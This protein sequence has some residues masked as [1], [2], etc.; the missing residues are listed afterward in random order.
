MKEMKKSI[1]VFGA[2]LIALLMVS[3]ATAAIILPLSEKNTQRYIVSDTQRYIVSETEVILTISDIPLLEMAMDMLDNPNEQEA[4]QAVI[5]FIED[6]GQITM[7]E[8]DELLGPFNLGIILDGEV[9]GNS[10]MVRLLRYFGFFAGPCNFN[11]IS[12]NVNGLDA[13][14]HVSWIFFMGYWDYSDI[15]RT[16]LHMI[17]WAFGLSIKTSINQ[18]TIQASSSQSI[19]QDIQQISFSYTTSKTVD[20]PSSQMSSTTTTQTIIGSTK[21]LGETASK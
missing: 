21:L 2:G 12:G 6:N 20:Q 7:G 19:S 4:L 17:G 10:P 15:Y 14:Q 9:T 1:M 16:D 5:E 13:P 8:L 11:L 18:E 3:S